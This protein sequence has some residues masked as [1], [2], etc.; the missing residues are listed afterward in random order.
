LL[1]QFHL[2]L[3]SLFQAVNVIAAQNWIFDVSAQL[4][5]QFIQYLSAKFGIVTGNEGCK[6]S[7]EN[8]N[9]FNFLDIK[10]I[11]IGHDPDLL[12]VARMPST[13]SYR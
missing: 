2:F 9:L 3:L 8:D 1:A 4:W 5:P 6:L 12:E 13:H 7:A 10:V 11:M